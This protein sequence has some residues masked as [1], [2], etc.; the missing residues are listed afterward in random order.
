MVIAAVTAIAMNEGE[1]AGGLFGLLCGVLCDTG[2]VS[3]VWNRIDIFYYSGVRERPSGNLSDAAESQER[4]AYDGSF[5]INLRQYIA[6]YNLRDVGIP[7][8]RDSLPHED[9]LLG[10]G[11]GRA[12]RDMFFVRAQLQAAFRRA[13]KKEIGCEIQVFSSLNP[14][15]EKKR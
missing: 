9:D 15:K 10:G 8:F 12:G 7:G 4:G 3:Y 14:G 13:S 2:G 5:C 6:L 11:D 1:F